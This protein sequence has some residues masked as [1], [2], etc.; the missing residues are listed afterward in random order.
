MLD[1]RW[2]KRKRAPSRLRKIEN[3]RLQ[4]R[5]ADP[6]SGIQADPGEHWHHSVLLLPLSQ[7]LLNFSLWET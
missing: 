4:G 5:Q 3:K 6:V 7:L 2:L 1:L